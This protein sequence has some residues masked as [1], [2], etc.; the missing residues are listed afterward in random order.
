MIVKS[1]S[2]LREPSFEALLCPAGEESGLS[3]FEQKPGVVL[4][5]LQSHS[6]RISRLHSCL[7]KCHGPRDDFNG[8]VSR[9]TCHVAVPRV[10]CVMLNNQH[11]PDI[12]IQMQILLNDVV[13]V[14]CRWR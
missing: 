5:P 1:S 2:N 12:K 9:V 3:L 7:L 8:R 13:A 14:S 4:V 11:F 6:V 10:M